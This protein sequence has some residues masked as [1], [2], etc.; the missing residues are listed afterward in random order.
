MK[1]IILLFIFSFALFLTSCEIKE[2]ITFNEDGSGEIYFGYNMSKLLEELPDQK[3]KKTPKKAIDSIIDFN[4]LLNDPKFKDSIAKASDEEK[5]KL[6]TLRNLKMHIIADEANKKMEFGFHFAFKNIDSI[7]DVFKDLKNAQEVTK[8]NKKTAM[9][10]DKP[11]FNSLTGENQKV[12][13]KYDGQFFSRTVALKKELS[14]KDKTEIDKSLKNDDNPFDKI[15]NNL[16][17]TIVLN[18]PKKIKK[19]NVKNAVFS[20]HKKTVTLT[21]NLED[22]MLR[23]ESINLKVKLAKD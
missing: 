8:L 12:T 13:Y 18:F 6:E 22:F 10:K 16:K 9:A 3:Q 4:T 1:K 23:P 21:Y 11:T 14:K 20:N 2:E 19:I 17:Y 15:L 5:A 7:K